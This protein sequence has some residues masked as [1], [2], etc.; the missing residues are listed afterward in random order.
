MGSLKKELALQQAAPVMLSEVFGPGLFGMELGEMA[1]LPSL[2][3]FAKAGISV[4]ESCY[5]MPEKSVAGLIFKVNGGYV[6]LHGKCET[7]DGNPIS[8]ILC[9]S[10]KNE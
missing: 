8:C 1:K 6:K 3:D 2:C 9:L 5:L 10:Q 7:C 4:S